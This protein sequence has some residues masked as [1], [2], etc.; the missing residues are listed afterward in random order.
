M[1]ADGPPI[2]K[3]AFGGGLKDKSAF[4][5]PSAMRA[6]AGGAAHERAVMEGGGTAASEAAVRRG[7]KWLADHQNADGSWAPSYQGAMTGFALLCFLGHGETSDSADYGTVVQKGVSW[8]VENGRK[9]DGHL[10]MQETFDQPGV[11]AHAIATYALGEYYIMSRDE[12][13][14]DLLK[15]AIGYI[16]DGQGPDGGWMYAYDKSKSDTSVSG[17]Q[18]QALKAAHN[19]G[20]NI[21]GVDAALDR[22][23]LNLKRV[24]AEDGSFGYREARPGSYCLTGAGVYCSY[25]WNLEKNK[26]VREGM[27]F[28]IK[29]TNKD[30]PVDYRHETADLYSWYYSTQACY[31]VGGAAWTRWNNLCRDQL[32]RNQSANGSWPPTAG[33]APG[34]ELQHDPEG[35]GPYYRTSLCVLM[36]E[37][38]YRYLPALR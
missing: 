17:W 21:D 10:N 8:L 37:V 16:V 31:L 19:S 38:Y 2:E 20:L 1:A 34:G 15:Q 35:A 4:T 9:N 5:I 36:L 23:M 6:R 29:Q 22:A 12:R 25:F 11:Y 14:A 30:H 24:Q 3:P 13:V 18:I 32:Y 33:K 28:L 7:L 27:E 26:S